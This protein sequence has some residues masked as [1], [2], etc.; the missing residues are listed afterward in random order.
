[1]LRGGSQMNKRGLLFL[2]SMLFF[3][4][5]PHFANAKEHDQ[6]DKSWQAETIYYLMIDRFHNGDQQNDLNVN[7]NDPY[8]FFGGD[9]QGVIDQLDYVKNLGFTTILLTP[10]FKNDDRGYHGYWPVDFKKTDEHFGSME[11]FIELVNQSQLRGLKVMVNFPIGLVGKNHP[12]VRETDKQDWLVKEGKPEDELPIVNLENKAVQ[13]YFIET[14]QWWITE[15]NIDGYLFSGIE[16]GP[17]TFWNK[18]VQAVKEVKDDVLILGDGHSERNETNLHVADIAFDGFLDYDEN[19]Q[20][21]TAFSA[22]DQSTTFLSQLWG[23]MKQNVDLSLVG[24]FMD[25]DKIERFTNETIDKNKHPGPRWKLALTYL[26][27]TPGIPIVFY[28]SEIALSGGESAENHQVMNFRTDKDLV[29]YLT[30]IGELRADLPSLTKGSMELLYENDGMIIYKRAYADETAIIA[31]NNTSETQAITLTSEFL[32]EGKELRG[33]LHG[34]M[35]RSNEHEQYDIVIDR[36]MAE[37][38]VLVDKTKINISFLVGIAAV[39]IVFGLF[40]YIVWRRGKQSRT[41]T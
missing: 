36:E 35:V 8:Q 15:T 37:I 3:S 14:A 18:L 7:K 39:W 16:F 38:Y 5:L 2:I 21:R 19:V 4:L 17:N 26:Y 13:D 24:T 32:E 41:S 27:T 23:E 30:K 40:L 31:L 12:W 29:D 20:I 28:G 11:Q 25:N 22:P 33:L 1:M 6:H 10:I 9:F 34:D